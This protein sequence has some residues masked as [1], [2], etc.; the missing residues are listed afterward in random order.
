MK[1]I[2][3]IEHSSI[4]IV[5][6]GNNKDIVVGVPHHVYSQVG[7]TND[8]NFVSK[9]VNAGFIGEYIGKKLNASLVVACNYFYD[10]NKDIKSDYFR[11]I[12]QFKPS[13]LIEIHGHENNKTKYDVEISSGSFEKNS[14]SIEFADILI[15]FSKEYK[16]LKDFQICGDFKYIY[17]KATKSKSINNENWVAFHI[18]LPPKLRDIVEQNNKYILTKKALLFAECLIKTIKLLN[19]RFSIDKKCH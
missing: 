18:E 10:V 9:D 6:K 2:L 5:Q 4:L 3:K 14:L 11:A 15:N 17:Y 8:D 16:L 7:I 1:D 13:I 19:S 12:L